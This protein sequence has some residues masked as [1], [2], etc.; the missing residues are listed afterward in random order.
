MG[1]GG[2]GKNLVGKHL[3]TFLSRL[4][5]V[6]A[7]EIHLHEI[8]ENVKLLLVKR[9]GVQFYKR[10]PF[11]QNLWKSHNFVKLIG[12]GVNFTK[13]ILLNEIPETIKILL[14]LENKVQIR[15]V[16]SYLFETPYS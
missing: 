7:K 4:A 3:G 1:P 15:S 13:E 14:K 5:P 16:A 8:C 12:G 2:S 9:K 11:K 6:R 10:N